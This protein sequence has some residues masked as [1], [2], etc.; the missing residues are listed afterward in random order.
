M[1][2][3]KNGFM[4]KNFKKNIDN[5]LAKRYLDELEKSYDQIKETSFDY[6]VNNQ[7]NDNMEYERSY[8]QCRR[9]L[10]TLVLKNWLDGYIDIS[11]LE[12][13]LCII[14]EEESW[15][16]PAPRTPNGIN[17]FT[18]ET[19]YAISEALSLCG[20]KLSETVKKKCIDAVFNRVIEPFEK[21]LYN[22]DEQDVDNLSSV[23]AGAVGMTA[24]YLVE[25]KER[26][27]RITDKASAICNV[28]MENCTNDG[29][30]MEGIWIWNYA[31]TYYVGYAVL[32]KQRMGEEMIDDW[33]KFKRLSDFANFCCIGNG[34]TISFSD[35][36]S[37]SRVSFGLA[38]KLGEMFDVEMPGYA[39]YGGLFDSS[40]SFC[41]SVRNIEWFNPA[42]VSQEERKENDYLL[43]AQWVVLRNKGNVLSMKGGRNDEPFNHNDVASFVYVKEN[44]FII[45]DLGQAAYTEEYDNDK[46][47][48]SYINTSSF[49][50]SVPIVNGRG[51]K[52]GAAYGATEFLFDNNKVIVSFAKSYDKKR[53]FLKELVRT[54]VLEDDSLCL[55][56]KFNF[57]R[58]MNTIEERLITY[59]DAEITSEN[60]VVLK[61]DGQIKATVEFVGDGQVN[62]K[63]DSFV[64]YGE[65]TPREF[66]IITF[67]VYTTDD[68]CEISCIIK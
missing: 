9:I 34:N 42:F 3:Y 50:H 4:A 29:A 31:M 45:T 66:N 52:N 36:F 49:G 46:Y 22:W 19:G 5:P 13:I 38:S 57:T 8:F 67:E 17:I 40:K 33:E 65:E 28:F 7:S 27:K 64:L 60:T 12:N 51:Q 24:L 63:K 26:L 56:D 20:E 11:K 6:L 39:Y 16:I 61:N 54:V 48:Y 15:S 1:Y 30:C 55:K 32:L 14:C 43:L 25:D 68:K 47:R 18:T 2:I 59:M 62:I 44:D 41:A 21:G 23:Y 35:S 53:T 37:D 10:I 58:K